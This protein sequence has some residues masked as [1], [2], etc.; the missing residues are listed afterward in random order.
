MGGTYSSSSSSTSA[1][2]ASDASKVLCRGTGL[3]K[4]VVGQKNNFTVDCSKAGEMTTDTL[5]LVA[6]DHFLTR[7]GLLL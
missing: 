6:N 2:L 7:L 3:S 4:A 1:K 5:R